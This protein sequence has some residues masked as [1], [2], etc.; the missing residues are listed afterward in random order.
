MAAQPVGISSALIRTGR[1]RWTSAVPQKHGF[2]DLGVH[3]SGKQRSL[4][5][6]SLLP[7][8][9]CTS[10]HQGHHEE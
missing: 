10:G 3:V 7:R 2:I 8:I 6:F 4:Y 9:S 1:Q 5:H